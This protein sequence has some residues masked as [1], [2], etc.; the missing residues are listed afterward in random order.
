MEKIVNIATYK[1]ITLDGDLQ[2]TRSRF[3]KKC[4]DLS[5]LGTILIA[6]EGVNI[7][8]AGTSDNINEF[9]QFLRD[10]LHD[11]DLFFKESFSD[12]QPFLRL[13]VKVKAQV[14]PVDDL[15][16]K[17]EE[18]TGPRVSPEE[19]KKWMDEDKDIVV[20]DTRNEFEVNIG[21]FKNA[22]DMKLEE[23]REYGKKIKDLPEE[24]KDKTIVTFCTGGIR[25]EKATPLMIKNGFKNVYQL[26]GGILN[27]FEKVGSD[28]YDGD[29]FVF[30]R[31]IA[32]NSK[33]E[34]TDLIKCFNCQHPLSPKE[35][36]LDTFRLG[37]YC[38][39]CYSK[40]PK[41]KKIK[42]GQ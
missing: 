40:T 11:E 25:C 4:K 26:D 5:L 7:I 31:R 36:S 38:P 10:E 29:C 42:S 24:W 19:F 16:I 1:F 27:Y 30:D 39:Y 21:T 8:A 32:L 2:E 35:Q 3:L 28:H 17:P 34:E 22:H 23:F 18:F 12:Y 9:K 14:I 20:L 13:V 15:E 37:Q 33:L 41:K 6:R